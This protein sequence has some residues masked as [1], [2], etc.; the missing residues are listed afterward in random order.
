LDGFLKEEQRK[1]PFDT[2]AFAKGNVVCTH[3]VLVLL[4]G[5]WFAGVSAK[6]AAGI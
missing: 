5:N 1:V 3:G 4:G 6:Q 2:Q